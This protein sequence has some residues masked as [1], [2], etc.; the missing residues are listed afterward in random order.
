MLKSFLLYWGLQKAKH[1]FSRE[2]TEGGNMPEIIKMPEL[3][4]EKGQ[5]C[6]LN[7]ELGWR[8]GSSGRTLA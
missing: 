6:L 7:P 3:P 2:F 4:Q 1:S 5:T 8:C